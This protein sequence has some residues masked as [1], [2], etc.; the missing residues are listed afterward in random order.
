MPLVARII[1]VAD[2]YDAM[3][4]DRPYRRALRPL[5]AASEVLRNAGSQFDPNWAQKLFQIVT[6]WQTS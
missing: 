6:N 3:T 1:A 2:G 4:S 5:E